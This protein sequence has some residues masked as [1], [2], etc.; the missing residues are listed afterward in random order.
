V[1]TTL[2]VT[3]DAW[4][5]GSSIPDMYAFCVPAEE[6]HVALGENKSPAISW[7]GAPEGTASF[8]IICTDPGVPED[9][10]LVN[11]EDI[12]IPADTSRF[13]FYHWVLVDVPANIDHLVEGSESEGIQP[14]GK[15]TGKT[16]HGIRGINDYTNWFAND[17]QM[18][19]NYGGYDGPCP[20]WN[21]DL[22]HVYNF[23]VYA[24]DVESMDL[25]ENFT[26]ADA[27]K[28]MQGHVLA[29]GSF[30][31]SFSLNPALR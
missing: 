12:N 27:E 6:N 16:D 22:V 4:E 25:S 24:L 8:A 3:I 13:T 10:G 29:Q 23:T 28:A 5:N 7:S 19:G 26:G 30:T 31:G 20:P 11:K 15:D 2:Q 1:T 9:L 18:K 21:D 17:E 14:G